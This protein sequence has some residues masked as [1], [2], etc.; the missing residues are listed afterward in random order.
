MRPLL[1]FIQNE[2]GQDMVEYAL[3]ASLVAIVSVAALKSLGP[4]IAAF[5]GTVGNAL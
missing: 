1:A 4:K 2:D 3:L 5:Y